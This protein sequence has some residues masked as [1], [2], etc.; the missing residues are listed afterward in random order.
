MISYQEAFREYKSILHSDSTEKDDL[1]YKTKRLNEI[2]EI[3]CEKD[4]DKTLEIISSFMSGVEDNKDLNEKKAYK[5]FID[6]HMRT[7]EY[8]V[9][10]GIDP[11][12]QQEELADKLIEDYK[13][14]FELDKKILARLVCLDRLINDAKKVPNIEN[15]Y[16]A[17]AGL[18]INELNSSSLDWRFITNSLDRKVRNAS[19]H[20]NFY[21]DP[22]KKLFYGENVVQRKKKK[23]FFK[24]APQ[25]FLMKILP[26]ATN[27]IQ[28]FIAASLILFLKQEPI[29]HDKAVS[30]LEE[31]I[32]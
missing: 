12:F 11:F 2:F 24:V 14:A 18:L 31:Q 25:E 20:L 19:S 15:T 23:E 29:L 13:R 9:R 28:S 22:E 27:V 26:H 5:S 7:R 17:S 3:S 1:R 4:L 8:I 16:Y 6:F 10:R 32:G 30:L 21:Y